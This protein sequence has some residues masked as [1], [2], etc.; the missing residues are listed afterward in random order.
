MPAEALVG[1]ESVAATSAVSMTLRNTVLRSK[2][3]VTG[4][5]AVVV[6]G[7][8]S[9]RMIRGDLVGCDRV[10]RDATKHTAFQLPI[11]WRITIAMG[12]VLRN[13]IIIPF[14]L[15]CLNQST[16]PLQHLVENVFLPPFCC[17][18]FASF[19]YLPASNTLK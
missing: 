9:S 11:D 12:T 5:V 3:G 4:A 8:L 1:V 10:E 6:V 13:D 7:R 2:S 19:I 16:S 18:D 14:E 17:T 15:D